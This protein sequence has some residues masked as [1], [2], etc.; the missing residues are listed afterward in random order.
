MKVKLLVSPLARGA[1][2][3]E[4]TEVAS[5]EFAARFPDTPF[6][7][8]Q[9]GGLVFL[10][11]SL[12]KNG[13]DM[14]VNAAAL[15]SVARLSFVQG[16]FA[17]TDTDALK[18]LQLEPDFLLPQ[19]LVYGWK[20]QGKTNEMAT[21]LAI[22]AALRYCDTGR[23][24]QTLLDPMAGKGTTLLWALRYGLNS[25]GIE[26]DTG[27]I[28]ALEGH[29][30]KQAKLHR[31]KHSLAKGSVGPRH[32]GGKGKFVSCDM[33]NHSLRLIAG[34]SREASKLLGEQR[35]DL[36]VTDLPYG[37][38]FKGGPKRSP[39]DTV[40]DCAK[41]WVE[42]LRSGGAMAI[43]FNTYQPTR[44]Q[45]EAVFKDL[46]CTIHDF[47]APHR[48]S[49]SIVRDVLVATRNRKE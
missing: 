16:A 33:G 35:F 39:I 17:V 49:E 7:V 26:Q 46:E 20:Y 25:V 11:A 12:D 9:F 45:L 27:A 37:V 8:E 40:K 44:V 42:R 24:P 38:Q 31:I 18:P 14:E 28:S 36:I 47:A 3:E 22:N 2:F 21:Q 41:T 19:Q 13:E 5:A 1:Y 43:M 32:K 34:D 6:E 10:S 29:L 15:Q 48:M 4:Y 23:A 30:K